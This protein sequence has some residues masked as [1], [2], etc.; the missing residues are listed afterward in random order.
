M[1]FKETTKLNNKCHLFFVSILIVCYLI[2]HQNNKNICIG[3]IAIQIK[4]A[5]FFSNAAFN[6][7]L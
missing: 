5:A 3:L 4:K 7:D 2:Q 6:N 1:F